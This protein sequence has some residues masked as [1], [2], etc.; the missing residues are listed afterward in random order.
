MP[1]TEGQSAPKPCL[2]KPLASFFLNSLWRE[3]IASKISL[4]QLVGRDG[5]GRSE[6]LGRLVNYKDIYG[7]A[8]NFQSR[9][10]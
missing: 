9:E 6:L 3:R 1:A 10:S 8:S 4:H 5:I 7:F 2:R